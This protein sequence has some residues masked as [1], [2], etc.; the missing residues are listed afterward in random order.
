MINRHDTHT[1][2]KQARASFVPTECEVEA[3]ADRAEA[4]HR[5][6]QC[7]VGDCELTALILPSYSLANSSI[8]G[9]IMRQGPHQ[10][11]QKSTS[12]GTE[13]L[14]TSASKVLSLT[15]VAAH[16]SKQR[17]VRN[18]KARTHGMTGRGKKDKGFGYVPLTLI[19]NTVTLRD[20][21]L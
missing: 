16:A 15:A 12:T 3:V 13:D 6:T 4:L 2:L 18:G 9:A 20:G 1:T 7:E 8:R 11:A 21:A 17:Q 19:H 14:S 10:G 5:R